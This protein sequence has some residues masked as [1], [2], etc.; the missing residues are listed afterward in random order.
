MP[1]KSRPHIKHDTDLV[2]RDGVAVRTNYNT[3]QDCHFVRCD[4]CMNIAIKLPPTADPNALESHSW[5][6][7]RRQARQAAPRTLVV[8]EASIICQAKIQLSTMRNHVG[9]H[10]LQEIRGQPEKIEI[11]NP[12]RSN[13]LDIDSKK[14]T[15]SSNCEGRD[16]TVWILRLKWMLNNVGQSNQ[17]NRT[18]RHLRLCLPPRKNGLQSCSEYP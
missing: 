4:I 5:A 14:L 9:K 11:T 8:K 6:C 1:T 7:K 16:L 3:E 2:L 15:Y 12:V 17:Y 18:R 10:I 13:P